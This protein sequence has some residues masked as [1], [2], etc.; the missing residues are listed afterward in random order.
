M[1]NGNAA[2]FMAPQG[3]PGQIMSGGNPA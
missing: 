3:N 2:Q 1:A